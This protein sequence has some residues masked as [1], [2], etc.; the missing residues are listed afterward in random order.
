MQKLVNRKCREANLINRSLRAKSGQRKDLI[1]EV[2]SDNIASFYIFI[3]LIH[4]NLHLK[5]GLRVLFV[6][7]KNYKN[8]M[9]LPKVGFRKLELLGA[10]RYLLALKLLSLYLPSIP[11]QLFENYSTFKNELL[12]IYPLD[13]ARDPSGT[14]SK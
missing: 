10:P 12:S 1:Y 8:C 4:R 7:K 5:N 2:S 3:M 9:R 14:R 13:H 11:T 6:R